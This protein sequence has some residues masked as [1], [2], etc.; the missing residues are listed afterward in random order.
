MNKRALRVGLIALLVGVSSACSS[1]KG[2]NDAES[3][4]SPADTG[5]ATAEPTGQAVAPKRK[6]KVAL[7]EVD[8]EE[9]DLDNDVTRSPE[10]V[11]AKD[12]TA[13]ASSMPRVPVTES[14]VPP[15][16]T[17]TKSTGDSG[18]ATKNG[19]H[20][21]GAAQSTSGAGQMSRE[22]IESALDASESTFGQCADT[23]ST[24]SARVVV[25]PNGS[26]S[27]ARVTQSVPDDPRLRDCLTEALRRLSFPA[28]NAPV[29]LSFS[30]AIEPV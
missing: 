6:F 18:A 30:L 1:T 26:V 11:V 28:T 22:N 9:S 7:L 24:F 15:P 20:K 27:E 17:T 16:Q 8:G 2:A 23:S 19:P 12:A 3:T 5:A 4:S 13:T 29:P 10:P 21:V 25:A 14:P